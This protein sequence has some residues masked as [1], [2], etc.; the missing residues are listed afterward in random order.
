MTLAS[1]PIAGRLLQCGKIAGHALS[2]D[3][4]VL[5]RPRRRNR[6]RHR[7]GR[8]RLPQR[9]RP[10]R[11][12]RRAGHPMPGQRHGPEIPQSGRAG[13][14]TRQERRPHRRPGP[15]RLRLHRDRH[16][17]AEAAG[18]QPASAP[19]PHPGGAGHHQPHGLQQRGR[20]QTAG[21]RARCGIP[22]ERRHPRHQHRQERDDADRARGRRLPGLLG[23]GL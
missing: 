3:P 11:L 8:H 12:P 20:R 17:H 7:H 13:R 14:R 2:V 6:P 22:E 16:R 1:A 23:Q 15:P 18:R 10:R 19:V 21:K 5:L 4:Q 9:H